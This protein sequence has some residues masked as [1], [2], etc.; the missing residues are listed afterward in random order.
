MGTVNS[1]L[2]KEVNNNNNKITDS[3]DESSAFEFKSLD[4]EKQSNSKNLDYCET[5]ENTTAK[6][7]DNNDIKIPF[8]FEW[9][10][11]GNVVKL[12]AGFLDNWHKELIMSRNNNTGIFEIKLNLPKGLHQFKFIVDGN[13]V[14]S[15]YYKIICDNKNI[16][17]NI[18]D[19]PNDIID[20]NSHNKNK[21]RHEKESSEY[22]CNYPKQSE[23]NYEAPCMPMHFGPQFNLN[24]QTN[25]EVLK[26]LFK[27]S[28]FLNKSKNILENESFKTIITLPHDKLSHLCINND[29]NNNEK[30]KYIRNSSTQRNKHKFLTLVYYSPKK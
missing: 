26:L 1:N 29:D 28:L 23:I 11:G 10:E 22:G 3:L 27:K 4:S 18:I 5:K 20:N 25:Q 2:S 14:C 12:A 21:K 15:R 13:W 24:F 8:L 7:A 30:I 19:L 6:L 16:A 9:K 17:N